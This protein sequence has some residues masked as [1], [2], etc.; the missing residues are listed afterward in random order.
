MFTA[1]FSAPQAV[2]RESKRT[3]VVHKEGSFIVKR[4]LLYVDEKTAKGYPLY[5]VEET[6]SA[7]GTYTIKKNRLVRRLSALEANIS[8][9]A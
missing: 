8:V 2:E 7:D 1:F 4:R 5:E 3:T 6:V 9:I